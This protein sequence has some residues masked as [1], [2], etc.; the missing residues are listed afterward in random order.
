MFTVCFLSAVWY[1]QPASLS[2]EA[3]D[4]YSLIQFFESQMKMDLLGFS[5]CISYEFL[6]HILGTCQVFELIVI[7]IIANNVN[8]TA[9][10]E[11]KKCFL[12]KL[13]YAAHV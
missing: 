6:V 10:K 2:T 1:N 9:A 13:W 8:I 5:W 3:Y 7:N 11:W 4:E 12:K